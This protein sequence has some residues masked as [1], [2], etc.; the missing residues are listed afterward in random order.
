MS[1][2]LGRPTF[3]SPTV[4]M[5]DSKN[6]H[7][8]LSDCGSPAALCSGSSGCVLFPTSQVWGEVGCS[9]RATG[10]SHTVH[11]SSMAVQSPMQLHGLH[12]SSAG[13]SGCYWLNRICDIINQSYLCFARLLARVCGCS[14]P[15]PCGGLDYRSEYNFKTSPSAI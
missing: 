1:E 2:G 10:P 12:Q 5:R 13:S 6:G 3:S 11:A 14:L 4:Q 15:V 7:A 8:P 9:S